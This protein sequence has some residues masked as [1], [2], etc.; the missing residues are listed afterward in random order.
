MFKVG[1][2]VLTSTNRTGTITFIDVNNFPRFDPDPRTF[3]EVNYD[4]SP[5]YYSI[6][7]EEE[8]TLIKEDGV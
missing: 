7:E 5:L 4:D 8:L 1:D 3:Y 2:R 6:F